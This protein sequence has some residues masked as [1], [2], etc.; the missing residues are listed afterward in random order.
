MRSFRQAVFHSAATR[1]LIGKELFSQKL[2]FCCERLSKV[3]CIDF[4]L[5]FLQR[6]GLSCVNLH[7]FKIAPFEQTAGC[8]VAS[9]T[10][11]RLRRSNFSGKVNRFTV[12]SYQWF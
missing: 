11:A 7:G 12:C 2:A 3:L 6:H 9:L 1:L 4:M 5:P 10:L 8:A